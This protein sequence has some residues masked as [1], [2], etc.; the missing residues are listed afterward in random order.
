[1]NMNMETQASVKTKC[2]GCGATLSSSSYTNKRGTL[3]L[4]LPDG[5]DDQGYDKNNRYDYCGESCMLAHLQNRAKQ[6][7]ASTTE[8]KASVIKGSHLLELDVTQGTEYL[9]AKAAKAVKAAEA[10]KLAAE[11][12]KK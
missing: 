12:T 11:A 6:A 10:A 8:A 5:Q 4:Y 3:S 7:K 2:D 9:K 1:M